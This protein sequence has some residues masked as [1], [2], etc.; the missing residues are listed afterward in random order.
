MSR[1]IPTDDDDVLTGNSASI[2]RKMSLLSLFTIVFVFVS[3]NKGTV[4]FVGFAV[5]V[6]EAAVVA[7]SYTSRRVRA[8]NTGSI[9]V[10]VVE[11]EEEEGSTLS[12]S[13]NTHPR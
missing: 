10:V 2:I 12:T 3:S 7:F 11:E 5:F 8:P 13:S 6:V 9:V 1:M 4:N